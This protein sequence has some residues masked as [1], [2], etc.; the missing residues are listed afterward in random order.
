MSAT[1]A[2]LNGSVYSY[3]FTTGIA[4]AYGGA[5]GYKA[6]SGTYS[7]VAMVSGDVD[8]D[9]NIFVSD[10]N[11]WAFG[12]GTTAGYY[13]SDLDFDTNVFVSDY[14]IWAAN[15]G[16]SFILGLKFGRSVPLF[17]SCVPK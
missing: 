17:I 3:D 7:T 12:F 11:V 2:T 5:T 16:T 6:I 10:Y 8:H 15:F 9:G 1:G 14:N 4:Q 13:L